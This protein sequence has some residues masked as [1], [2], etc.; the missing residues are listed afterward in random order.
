MRL[1]DVFRFCMSALVGARARTWLM[2]LAMAIGVSSV[3]LLT[4][5]GEGTRRYVNNQFMNLGS[6]LLIVM[7]GK[8]E[9]TGGQPPILSATEVDLTIDDAVALGQ[10]QSI[11]RV[12]PMVLGNA[13]VSYGQRERSVNVIGSTAGLYGVRKL[14]MLSGRF[15]PVGDPT[16]GAAI[17]VI[18]DTL[19]TELFGSARAL[20]ERIRIDGQKFQVIGVLK[21][22]SGSGVGM[23]LRDSAVIPVATAQNLFDSP[24]LFRVMV[25]ADGHNAIPRAEK[26]IIDIL[27]TRH[28]GEEDVT[29]ITQDAMLETFNTILGTLTLAVGGIAAISL[30]VA[31]VLI[32]N[33]MLVAVSQRKTEIGL[34]KAIGSPSIQILRLFL[35][36]AC[37]L[38]LLGA[39]VG[40]ILG[41]AGVWGLATALP[42]F[43]IGVPLWA[44]I[45][46][47]AT[48]LGTGLVF[49]FIPAR[50]AAKLDP[51]LALAGH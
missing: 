49:C 7:P 2:L 46:A 10:S 32:M 39:I 17:A 33:V 22:A 1:D 14:K 15:L 41:F 16:R 43:P 47:T 34:L 51:V 19:K 5:V 44:P 21:E 20:G 26:A 3:L 42:D 48:S 11:R 29:V 35:A 45:A 30:A 9:T 23:D 36:E 8:L 25:E 6:H 40:L 27:R 28:N 13:P 37:M 31:G 50:R 18:G 24:S 38:A 12:A 4:A